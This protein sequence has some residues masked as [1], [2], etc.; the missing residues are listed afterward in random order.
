MVDIAKN[1]PQSKDED[2]NK[3]FKRHHAHFARE[4]KPG[5]KRKKEDDQDELYIL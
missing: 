3:K 5:R 2:K 4:D 1:C